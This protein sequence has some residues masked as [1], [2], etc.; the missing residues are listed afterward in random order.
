MFEAGGLPRA[1]LTLQLG[2]YAGC[3]GAHWWNLQDAALPC[4]SE[5][6]GQGL[7][8]DVLHR[9]GRSPSGQETYTPRLILMDLKGNLNT[10]PQEGCLYGDPKRDTS[11]AWQ[12]NLITHQEDPPTR[13]LFLQDL[14]KLQGCLSSEGDLGPR[15]HALSK[16]GSPLPTQLH[17][18]QKGR[19]LEG[20]VQVWSDYLRVR[21]HPRSTCMIRQYNYDGESCQLEAFGQGESLLHDP[22]YQEELEDRLHF[23]VEECDYLQGFQILCDLDNG[24]SGVGAKV[25]ELLHDEYSGRGILTWGLT[26]VIQNTEVSGK[27]F[28]RLMNTVLGIVHL[29]SHSSLFCPLSL[30]GSLGLRPEA[31]VTLP[32]AHYEASLNYHSSAIL[33]TALD[34]LSVPYRLQSSPISMA[35]LADAF[36]VSGRKVVTAG[37]ALPFP[38]AH[39]QSLP[40]ALCNYQLAVPWALLSSCGEPKDSCCFGQAVVLR[41]IGKEKQSCNC[42]PGSQPKSALH[43]CG[44]GEEVLECYLHAQF[45]ET[46]STSYLLQEPCKVST[47]YPQ[48]FSALL[49][50]QGFL[51]DNPPRC[52]TA[53]ESIPVLT[54][55]QSSPV[56]Y[57]ALCRLYKEL[58][59]VNLRRCAS[60]FS[61]GVELSDF[62]EAL[63]ELRTLAQCYE[64][65][66][67]LG[68]SEDEDSD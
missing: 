67:V 39:D 20:S 7:C 49:N 51:L 10:L 33:A 55:V 56:L 23:Y 43:A 68:E 65:S 11:V 21:L 62:Q 18:S 34:T 19:P 37:A 44:T 40:D 46:F 32:Y 26:P 27:D 60:Y 35:Q 50:T 42:P 41:G 47:P 17:V 16:D 53:L 9:A 31:P 30:S 12:G 45:P 52:S 4:S 3:V 6:Q 22:T 64:T 57:S 54:A 28:Y 58:Q 15:A 25:T 5:A 24:F 66:S 2:G 13:N 14:S 36:N 63:H 61:A 8:P 1:A 59:R 48:F 29:S 38:M